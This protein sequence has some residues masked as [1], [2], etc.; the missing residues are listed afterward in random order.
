MAENTLPMAD[1]SLES[2]IGYIPETAQDEQADTE[3]DATESQSD[4]AT[5][6]EQAQPSDESAE[7]Q[8][9][10]ESP[11]EALEA[12]SQEDAEAAPD[13]KGQEKP[14]EQS[15]QS[16]Q[17]A[18][19]SAED[20]ER[21]AANQERIRKW[22]ADLADIETKLGR[23]DD[24]KDSYDPLEDGPKAM[25]VLLEGFNA[26]RARVAEMSRQS[27]QVHQQTEAEKYWTSYARENPE[28]GARARDLW[29]EAVNS[30]SRDGL[31]GEALHA[32][33]TE[34][35]K[36]RV[37]AIK[38]QTKAKAPAKAPAKPVTQNGARITPTPAPT[39]PPARRSLSIEDRIDAGEYGN[40]SSII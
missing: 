25:R 28:V 19:P 39:R 29:Q 7:Q 14:V 17:S 11:Q 15:A 40:L 32:V 33:A 4:S 1:L 2:E 24:A 20:Q 5:A 36:T 35:W 37:Q 3:I 26:M 16:A 9:A 13:E 10:A 38:A 8:N 22:M 34:R 27:A 30:A 21:I 12:K 31:R 6:S 23:P 18:Q